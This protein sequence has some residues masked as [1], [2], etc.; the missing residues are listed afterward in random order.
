MITVYL[1][2]NNHIIN[3]WWCR[4]E[5]CI[6]WSNDGT[7]YGPCSRLDFLFASCNCATLLRY[8]WHLEKNHNDNSIFLVFCRLLTMSIC[9]YAY[10]ELWLVKILKVT[11]YGNN[12][13]DNSLT[14]K[15]MNYMIQLWKEFSLIWN[16]ISFL[17]ISHT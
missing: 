4:I 13:S 10:G 3:V 2:H 14:T 6:A 1:R 12:L 16:Y 7:Y 15:V 8:D 17:K 9:L 11:C 5:Y